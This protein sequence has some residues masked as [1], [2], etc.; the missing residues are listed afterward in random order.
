MPYKE[1]EDLPPRVKKNLP[2]HA[3]EIYVSAY[4]NAWNEYREKKNREATA[5]RVAWSVVK[6]S[7]QKDASG[8]WVRKHS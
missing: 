7:Y 1:I 4:N 3:A 2:R 6:K 5:H 8:H